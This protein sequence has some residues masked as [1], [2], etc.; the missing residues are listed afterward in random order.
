[1]DYYRKFFSFHVKIVSKRAA[2]KSWKQVS[3]KLNC[4]FYNWIWIQQL[5]L[6]RIRIRNPALLKSCWLFSMYSQF[7]IC[8]SNYDGIPPCQSMLSIYTFLIS[9][10]SSPRQSGLVPVLFFFISLLLSLVIIL[11]QPLFALRSFQWNY[12]YDSTFFI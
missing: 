12:G 11:S 3:S 9:H 2:Y 8:F 6:M 4:N 7:Q 5:K 1:M 10:F